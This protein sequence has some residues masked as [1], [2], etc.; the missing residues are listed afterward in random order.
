MSIAV[1]G[2]KTWGPLSPGERRVLGVLVE[3]A[4]TTPENY[5]LSLNATV[6]GCNQKSN[7]DPV[8]NYDE[9][10]VEEILE[11][12]RMKGATSRVEGVGRVV[13]W[14]HN[15]YDWL[16]VKN[17]P[18]ELAVL[19]E[20]LLRGPQTEGDLRTRASRMEPI[21]DL[22]AL[23]AVLDPL[24]ERGLV[25]RLSPPEV[26]RGV[27]VTHGLYP[28]QEL[29]RLRETHA[30]GPPPS[31]EPRP[32]RSVE[33]AAAPVSPALVEEVAALRADLESLRNTVAALV[34]EVRALK[35]ELGA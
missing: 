20:L 5:P 2:E 35:S 25:V 30:S 31:D 33:A 32:R 12:L 7:R 26:V 13:K 6:S 19:V 15:L 14:K 27:M 24:M 21:A 17:R 10:D 28:P 11:G 29:E 4:K 8:T 18:V 1:E 9:D 23:Q 16:G 34:A 22:N 3:K